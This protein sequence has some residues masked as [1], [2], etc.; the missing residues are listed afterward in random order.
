MMKTLDEKSDSWYI[1]LTAP[2]TEYKVK[3]QLDEAGI[4]NF[5]PRRTS[6]LLWRNKLQERIVPVIPRCV[7]IRFSLADKEQLLGI[8]SLLLPA[9]LFSFRLTDEQMENIRILIRDGRLPVD[10]LLQKND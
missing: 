5:L 1:V 4:E 7:F 8:D 3:R 10:W 2:Y 9:D 6:R